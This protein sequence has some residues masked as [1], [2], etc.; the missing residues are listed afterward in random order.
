M[1]FFKK[2]YFAK[3]LFYLLTIPIRI[4]DFFFIIN[5]KEILFFGYH[6]RYNGNAK[7][8]YEYYIKSDSSLTPVWLLDEKDLDIFD[9]KSNKYHL[10]P[11][12]NCGFWIHC[13]LLFKL[14]RAKVIVVTSV[15]DLHIYRLMLSKFRHVEILLPHGITLK[16]VG[17][18]A[19]HL[20][21]DRKKVWIDVP[22][23]FDL[24]SVGS[25]IEKYLISTGFSFPMHKIKILGPQRRDVLPKKLLMREKLYLKKV[26]LSN[27]SITMN[28]DEIQN[29]EFIV[30]APTHRDHKDN[31]ADNELGTLLYNL[32][33]FDIDMLDTFLYKNNILLFLREHMVAQ[34]STNKE[35]IQHKMI[36]YL[37]PLD[38]PDIDSLI[39]GFD[40]LITDYSGIYLELLE[41][42]MSIAFMPYDLEEY[43]T[44]RGLIL[45]HD[46]L[47]AGH[48]ISS[49]KESKYFIESVETG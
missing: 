33:G 20:T 23:R 40:L 29:H 37:S 49:Q 48:I 30:Y 1:N 17:V 38:V 7:V 46:N 41:S 12:K 10:L 8:L 21:E 35:K 16:S 2:I 11:T 24:I 34:L 36:H 42:D 19:K 44:R 9:K 22:K 32:E 14:F 28:D 5:K 3:F 47:F 27:T 13:Q 39:Y 15:G 43:E 26:I 6:G 18:M 4:F 45:P 31:Y 25:R